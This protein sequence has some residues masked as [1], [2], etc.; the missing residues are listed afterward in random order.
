[1]SI[2]HNANKRVKKLFSDI[3]S[4]VDQPLT[5]PASTLS[6][7]ANLPMEHMENP[8]LQP[9]TDPL[10]YQREIELLNAR[11]HELETLLDKPGA[12]SAS[13]IAEPVSARFCAGNPAFAVSPAGVLWPA[14]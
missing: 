14:T 6:T 8:A 12:D 1:M 7:D 11:I 13:R 10:K 4:I 3:K 9:Q 5:E 2:S